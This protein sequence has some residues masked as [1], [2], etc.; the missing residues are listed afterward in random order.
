MTVPAP[1][2]STRT[3]V[4]SSSSSSPVELIFFSQDEVCEEEHGLYLGDCFF[5]ESQV[6]AFYA[7]TKKKSQKE[8]GERAMTPKQR[9]EFNKAKTTTWQ[10]LLEKRAITVLPP[11]QAASVR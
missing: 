1:L 11:S 9:A 2:G 3:Q 5:P 8:V 10:T 4:P 6:D 7:M